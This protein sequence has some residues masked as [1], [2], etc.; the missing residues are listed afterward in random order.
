MSEV[1]PFQS[2]VRRCL[3][4]APGWL[5]RLTHPIEHSDR[6]LDKYM[7]LAGLA[8]ADLA[9]KRILDIGSGTDRT[10]AMQ[11]EELFG[12]EVVCLDPLSPEDRLWDDVEAEDFAAYSKR[13]KAD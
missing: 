3:K 5:Y 7:R 2:P 4:K 12:A 13:H 6:E 11:A 8:A 1:S 10:F 9:G